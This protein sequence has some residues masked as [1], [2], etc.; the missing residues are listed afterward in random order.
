MNAILLIV[1]ND[2]KRR[3]R[4]PVSI[5]CMFLIPLGLTLLVGLVFGRHGKVELSHIKVLIADDDRGFAAN[6]LKQGMKQGKLAELIDLVEVD[7]AEGRSL[8]DRGKASALIEIPKGFTANI[9]DR[10]PAEIALVK[11]PQESFLPLIVEEITE[12]MAVMIDGAAQIFEEPIGEARGML[13]GGRWPE[14]AE[15]AG[16]LAETKP[17]IALVKGYLSDTLISIGSE[18]VSAP[19]AEPERTLNFFALIMPGS[20]LIG[21]LFISEITMRDILREREAGTLARILAGPVQSGRV[22]AG[23]MLSSFAIT[24]VACALLIAIGRLAF[25]IAWG[26]PLKLLAHVVGSILLCVGLMAFFYGFIRSERVADAMLPVVI[27]VLC[28]FGGAMIPFEAMSPAMQRA[29][30]FSPS[31]WVIDGLKRISIERTDWGG[32]APHLAIVYGLGALTSL[33]GAA[34]LRG[35][36]GGRG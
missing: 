11:N 23:K 4:S 26:S 1:R 34:K 5:I 16:L 21:L 18:T 3:L 12:T 36:L 32:I 33:A 35:K 8:M 14:A 28:I 22:V 2:M 24:L 17:R 29:A 20:I 31:F 27:I 15:L 19:G 13:T 30:V 10:K 9:L 7:P 25:G 6:F